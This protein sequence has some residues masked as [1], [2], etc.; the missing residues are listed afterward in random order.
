MTLPFLPCMQAPYSGSVGKF[1]VSNFHGKRVGVM[2]DLET[3]HR[4]S[5]FKQLN[6]NWAMPRA[7]QKKHKDIKTM[8]D[9]VPLAVTSQSPPY[10]MVAYER[11][12]DMRALLRRIRVIIYNYVP[13]FE[14]QLDIKQIK[15]NIS[16]ILLCCSIEY[17]QA[18]LKKKFPTRNDVPVFKFVNK[19]I[20]SIA[21][22]DKE[23][24]EHRKLALGV[25]S[26][27]GETSTDELKTEHEDVNEWVE[28]DYCIDHTEL[29]MTTD[30]DRRYIKKG[31]DN[32][33]IF[34][35][36]DEQNIRIPE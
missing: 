13:A 35:R 29:T 18:V 8:S 20:E 3:G 15:N 28:K 17:S 9:C 36:M 2:D 30:A 27:P 11:N 24:I 33:E 5:V 1:E 23:H 31:L 22:M 32:F 34:L 16:I 12:D 6:G 10:D 7:A 25:N 21:D 19:S 26:L 14:A 4:V